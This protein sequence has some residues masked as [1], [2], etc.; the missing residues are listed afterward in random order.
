MVA[1]AASSGLGLS[2]EAS[3]TTATPPTAQPAPVATAAPTAPPARPSLALPAEIRL[4]PDADTSTQSV[5]VPRGMTATRL[6]ARV[7]FPISSRPITFAATV[8]GERIAVA[9]SDHAT[10]GV[11]VIDAALP[12]GVGLAGDS[13]T[14][15]VSIDLSTLREGSGLVCQ[16]I[17]NQPAV[18]LLDAGIV[19]EGRAEP[20]ATIASFFD[21]SVDRVDIWSVDAASDPAAVQMAASVIHRLGPT[22]VIGFHRGPPNAQRVRT[23]VAA[24]P[25]S[26]ARDLVFHNATKA[27]TVVVDGTIRPTLRI[28]GSSADLLAT[29]Q[30]LAKSAVDIADAPISGAA[31]SRNRAYG[32][33]SLTVADL[34][35]TRAAVAPG[36]PGPQLIGTG[37]MQWQTSVPQSR[38][39]GPVG[40][41]SVHLAGRSTPLSPGSVAVLS[42]LWNG[43]IV[44]SAPMGNTGGFD[45]R[46]DVPLGLIGR[47]N[48]LAL[49]VVYTPAGGAC[50][51]LA[52]P[53]QVDIDPLST[54]V[55]ES[56]QTLPAGFTRFPQVLR[57]RFRY[58]ID[59]AADG[60]AALGSAGGLIAALQ[61]LSPDLLTASL[62][63]MARIA[64][65]T[66]GVIVNA[67]EA[68][69]RAL[70]APFQFGRSRVI[71]ADGSAVAFEIAGPVGALQ[72]FVHKET[73]L[74]VAGGTTPALAD[75]AV[76]AMVSHADGWYHLADQIQ[77]L[78]SRR[79]EL[80]DVRNDA[81]VEAAPDKLALT[82]DPSPRRFASW[83]L[84]VVL[85]LLAVLVFRAVIDGTRLVR[86]RRRAAQ[87]VASDG[88][89]S[90]VGARL[91]KRR[92]TRRE[93]RREGSQALRGLRLE[94]R[95]SERRADDPVERSVQE[96]S[97]LD[98]DANADDRPGPSSPAD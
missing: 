68:T 48:T 84:P 6:T 15:T 97:V 34:T 57:G 63:P 78:R 82:A 66:A 89:P 11:A 32:R 54:V 95:R 69:V 51:P 38:F 83:V 80:I 2:A 85:T 92:E 27:S 13:G 58:A 62:V 71:S 42:V 87:V 28:E 16:N 33:T 18:R 76:K 60:V 23:V 35:G 36:L 73:N 4:A 31:T 7:A 55:G 94:R 50:S 21:P 39:G 25:A 52:G 30:T 49:R 45:V 8:N 9:T 75:D 59:R 3:T 37:E 81:I 41:I 61:R 67:S 56:G 65:G 98:H 24:T 93:P 86:L 12:A 91:D 5:T 96:G 26:N 29:A 72:A 79:A 90:P 53:I 19:T 20:P 22:T 70:D 77:V 46:A 17:V 44:S 40:H 1:L 10:N 64:D 88:L 43:G 14:R 47:D 74:V